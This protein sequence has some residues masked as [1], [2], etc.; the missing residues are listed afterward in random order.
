MQF[1][2]QLRRHHRGRRIEAP[3]SGSISGCTFRD[4]SAGS[5]GGG[6]IAVYVGALTITNSTI[7]DNSTSGPGGGILVYL[8]TLTADN[9]TIADNSASSGGGIASDPGSTLTIGNTI[10][11][12]N[13]ATT[14]GP[15]VLGT[16]TS[17]GNNLIGETDGSTG[18]VSS[19]LTGTVAQPLD[20]MLAASGQ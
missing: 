3:A 17:Q 14:S 16:F 5:L 2:G 13:T 4:N 1:H 9:D 18:W 20:P 11:A 12:G 15:D 7:A 6:G 19:D 8:G 10:V